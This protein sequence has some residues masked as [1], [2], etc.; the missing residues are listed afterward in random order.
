MIDLHFYCRS[1][2]L[3]LKVIT[4]PDTVHAILRICL[5]LTRDY[6]LAYIFV[7]N[8][9]VNN[10]VNLSDASNFVG[11]RPLATLLLRHIF[12]EWSLLNQAMRNVIQE[13]LSMKGGRDYRHLSQKEFNYILRRLGPAICRSEDVFIENSK[14]MMRFTISVPKRNGRDTELDKLNID[15]LPQHVKLAGDFKN[16][17]NISTL[18][19]PA[20]QVLRVLLDCLYIN[21]KQVDS[22]V[23]LTPSENREGEKPFNAEADKKSKIDGTDD[24]KNTKVLFKKSVILQLL[25]ELVH[26]YPICCHFITEYIPDTNRSNKVIEIST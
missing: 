8:N 14:K 23:T 16:D 17:I 12:E 19:I 9:G 24:T 6:D 7:E 11:F 4:D 3:L 1:C 15:S 22:N 20:Q 13:V 5:R 26:S 21:L 25:S 10:L 2:A 18:P